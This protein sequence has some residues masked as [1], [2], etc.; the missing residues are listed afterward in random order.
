MKYLKCEHNSLNKDAPAAEMEWM[1]SEW[2]EVPKQRD[3]Y[4]CGP[5]I[6][7]FIEAMVEEVPIRFSEADMQIMYRKY[8]ARVLLEYWQ[9]R[10]DNEMRTIDA[11]QDVE[12]NNNNDEPPAAA[13]NCSAGRDRVKANCADNGD[14][15]QAAYACMAKLA[16]DGNRVTDIVP[17]PNEYAHTT[18]VCRTKSDQ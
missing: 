8:V 16:E 3:G 17:D 14:T 5:F 13:E 10:P 6:L 12:N 7:A 15:E 9:R 11:E 4:S 18:Y 1:I 2:N